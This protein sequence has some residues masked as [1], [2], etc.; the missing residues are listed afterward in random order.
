MQVLLENFAFII[1][2]KA[3]F[4]FKKQLLLLPEKTDW[5]ISCNKLIMANYLRSKKYQ[6]CSP[7]L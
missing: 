4:A 1:I 2:A 3:E 7:T 6:P 5:L